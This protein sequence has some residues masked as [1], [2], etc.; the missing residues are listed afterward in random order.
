MQREETSQTFDKRTVSLRKFIVCFLW[1]ITGL[2]CTTGLP[3]REFTVQT[4]GSLIIPCHY[5][6]KYIEHKKYWCFDAKGAYNYCSILA[7]ANE[8]K[9]KVSVIDHPDQS[10]FIVTMRNLQYED[11]G[12]YWCAVEIEGITWDVTE[13]LHL[14]VQSVPDVSVVSSSVSGHEGGDISVECL[15]SSGYQ[16]KTKRWCRYKDQS[17]YTVGRTDTSQNSSVQIIDDGRRSFTVLMTGLRLTD[18][19]WYFCSVGKQE[20]PVQLTVTGPKCTTGSANRV[21]TVQTGGSLIIPCH[22]ERK[23]TEHKKYWC[24]DAK[25]AYNYCSILAYAN[26]TKGKV[27]VI[28]HPE[29][30]FFTVTMRNLQYEDTGSYWCA[31]EI[32]GI[33]WDVA[34][35][36]HLTVQSAPDVSVVS[37]SV[38]GHEGGDVSVQCLY[39]SEYQ[40]KVK[41]WCRYKDKSCYKVGRTNTSQNSSVQITDDGKRSFTVLMT[42]LRLTDSGWYFCSAGKQ[43]ALVEL[44]VTGV[45]TT[46]G[47]E[48]NR[49]YLYLEVWIP[50]VVLLMV[51]VIVMSAVIL[52][53]HNRNEL[54]TEVNR[55]E[56]SDAGNG[57]SS[58][59]ALAENDVT[60]T[61]VTVQPKTKVSSPASVEND[62]TYSSVKVQSKTK[63]DEVAYSSVF[64]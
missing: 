55:D 20:A 40:K 43:E 25:A 15:Y 6:R 5:E 21:F 13:Y 53:K 10:F 42:G 60:Y 1:L 9:G 46:E 41:Q 52:K 35:Q 36:L 18:S 19:G 28:D 45:L 50:A 12:S 16:N 14:T 30:S 49:D 48:R 11:T 24:F 37:S 2:K 34:E 27:S 4:G 22:Y 58:S 63:E 47:F 61:S 7:Y 26:E 38:S 3:N 29:Q 59:S 39:S 8:T 62:V 54:V 57:A 32:E 51:I 31:V 44:N 64:K 17:C 23:Y 56:A 33:T